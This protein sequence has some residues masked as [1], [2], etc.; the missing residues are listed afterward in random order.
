MRRGVARHY[1]QLAALRAE[2]TALQGEIWETL[3]VVLREDDYRKEMAVLDGASRALESELD[4]LMGDDDDDDDDDDEESEEESN[5]S[6][7]DP[8]SRRMSVDAIEAHT[9]STPPTHSPQMSQR[10]ATPNKSNLSGVSSVSISESVV[11]RQR[12]LTDRVCE[13]ETDSRMFLIEEE[14]CVIAKIFNAMHTALLHLILNKQ[15]QPARL[16]TSFNSQSLSPVHT[17]TVSDTADR[18]SG[19]ATTLYAPRGSSSSSSRQESSE[20]ARS[21]SSVPVRVP[22]AVPQRVS[23]NESPHQHQH[24]HQYQRHAISPGRRR[25]SPQRS[26]QRSPPRHPRTPPHGVKDIRGR[27]PPHLSPSLSP[28]SPALTLSPSVAREVAYGAD[29][30]LT[31][32]PPR[33]EVIHHQ[34]THCEEAWPRTSVTMESVRTT[35]S[36]SSRGATPPI[37]E[38]AIGGV[39][40]NLGSISPG[41]S[42]SVSPQEL[43]R[44]KQ[45][46][47]SLPEGAVRGIFDKMQ[48]QNSAARSAQ[49]EEVLWKLRNELHEAAEAEKELPSVPPVSALLNSP[50]HAQVRQPRRTHSPSTS[51][52]S[53]SVRGGGG[54]GGSHTSSVGNVPIWIT[55]Q[56]VRGANSETGYQS[57]TPSPPA[58]QGRPFC[59]SSASQ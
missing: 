36:P 13:E 25:G 30:H 43:P 39:M 24:Q 32:L 31:S 37:A 26:P 45:M 12:V 7:V 2:Y 20:R 51:G 10:P 55:G 9:E 49:R 58:K 22:P 53:A 52:V 17:R 5:E 21:I 3:P 41:S 14:A 54:G 40:P 15:T 28:Y 29:P 47:N 19:V 1:A 27:T 56:G 33:A 44:W 11:L 34:M 16:S 50:L 6:S 57:R 8:P 46:V 18:Y 23:V 38:Y 48:T 35:A 42:P 59:S 4:M